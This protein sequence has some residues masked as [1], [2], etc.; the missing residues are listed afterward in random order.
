VLSGGGGV[1]IDTLSYAGATASV[2]YDLT[3]QG[4]LV[5][6]GGGGKDTASG[7]ENLTGGAGADK[8]TGDGKDNILSGGAGNDIL[9]GGDGEDIYISGAGADKITDSGIDGKGDRV[10]LSGADGVGDTYDLGATANDAME[11]KGDTAITLS[12]F[13][14]ASI[15]HL[16]ANGFNVVGT[17]A[18]D[19]INF[20]AFTSVINLGTIDGL[21][22]NDILTGSLNADTILGGIGNDI[23]DGKAGADHLHGG[24]GIDTLTGGA[25]AD[26]FHI[27]WGEGADK[28]TDFVS[29]ADEIELHLTTKGI[30][31]PLSIVS[32]S[33]PTNG[34]LNPALLY[35]SD[36]GRVFYD[37]GP[38]APV[39]IATLT[40]VP[41]SIQLSDFTFT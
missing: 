29:G 14:A 36:D 27:K 3:K 18:A 1:G 32:G 25:D 17:T 30:A 6:T 21:A 10:F 33:A 40:N 7:F 4:T 31:P 38:G 22:G 13:S 20:S 2:T 35:D 37:S 41:A 12:K 15:E 28:I 34:G 24:L 26:T 19:N 5:V 23:L 9:D 8:L 16:N 39:L 11:F